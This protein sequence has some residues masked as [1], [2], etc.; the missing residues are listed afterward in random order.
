MNNTDISFVLFS[1]A[2]KPS[3][4]L[5]IISKFHYNIEIGLFPHILM[6]Y[7]RS[8]GNNLEH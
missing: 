1:Q 5:I 3:M 6:F 4:N 8:F 7:T 2:S